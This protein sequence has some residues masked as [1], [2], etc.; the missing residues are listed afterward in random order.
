MVESM[1][2]SRSSRRMGGSA[3][4]A[5]TR[6][7]ESCG[8]VGAYGEGAGG[9]ACTHVGAEAVDDDGDDALLRHVGQAALQEHL[10]AAHELQGLRTRARAC[11]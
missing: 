3:L 10:A 11:V 7:R 4:F 5:N 1:G 2:P 8:R 6:Q 9:G